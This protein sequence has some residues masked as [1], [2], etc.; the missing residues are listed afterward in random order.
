[1]NQLDSPQDQV[2]RIRPLAHGNDA[3][4]GA[5]ECDLGLLNPER[6]DA[7]RRHPVNTGDSSLVG[8]IGDR[9]DAVFH[10]GK[11]LD[12]HEVDDELRDL[13]DVPH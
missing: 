11:K 8:P 4:Q 3:F 6:P 7:C 5:L 9:P 1:M 2:P 10:N 13:T 12:G